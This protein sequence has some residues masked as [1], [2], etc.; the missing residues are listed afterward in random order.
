MTA[1]QLARKLLALSDDAMNMEVEVIRSTGRG[2][3]L[4]V[5]SAHLRRADSR[6]SFAR[7]DGDHDRV[8]IMVEPQP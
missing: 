8:V 6:T 5:L 3:T 7:K 2:Q 4:S 1:L